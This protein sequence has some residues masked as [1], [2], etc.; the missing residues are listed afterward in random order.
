MPARQSSLPAALTEKVAN[1][2]LPAKSAE[3]T[4][5]ALVASQREAIERA[6]TGTPV[7]VER[8]IRAVQTLVRKPETHLAE[9]TPLSFLGA[10]VTLAQ[11]GLEPGPLGLSYIEARRNGRTGRYEARPG[12]MYRGHVELGMRSGRL[13]RIGAFDVHENDEFDFDQA[14]GTVHHTWDLR[15]ERGAVYGHYGIADLKGGGR[16]LL[17]MSCAEAEGYRQ[18]S[19]PG[20]K[21]K[22]PWANHPHAMHRKTVILRMEPYL[23][24]SS[25]MALAFAADG[26]TVEADPATGETEMP[27]YDYDAEP[28]EDDEPADAEPVPAAE[29]VSPSGDTYAEGGSD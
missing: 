1:G 5:Y 16:V 11:L 14:E 7:S 22:G 26:R 4:N 15:A 28:V 25:E 23:P 13:L 6:L 12:V 9:C 21:G 19:A 29:W 8:Y 2:N 20:S 17:V 24:K 3:P 10:V 18:Y 27:A